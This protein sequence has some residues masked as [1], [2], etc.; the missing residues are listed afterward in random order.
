[1]PPHPHPSFGHDAPRFPPPIPA[2]VQVE[3]RLGVS[4]QG[5]GG[6]RRTSGGGHAGPNHGRDHGREQGHEY[7]HDRGLGGYGAGG[8]NAHPGHP[9][10]AYGPRHDDGPPGPPHAFRDG[11]GRERYRDRPPEFRG[12]ADSPRR[13]DQF[14][15][16]G[17]RR[18]R[19]PDARRGGPPARRG[20]PVRSGDAEIEIRQDRRKQ[21]RVN[22]TL[23]LRNVSFEADTAKLRAAFQGFGEI[24]EWFDMIATRGMVFCHYYD[25]RAAQTAKEQMHGTTIDRRPIDV[26]YSLPKEK[27]LAG[28]CD[29]T[30]N[31]GAVMVERSPPGPLGEGDLRH[32]ASAYGDVKRV[33][34]TRNNSNLVVEFW[35]SRAAAAFARNTN[36]ANHRGARLDARLVWEQAEVAEAAPEL[37]QRY[38]ARP[39]APPPPPPGD[40]R[41]EN[42]RKVQ[43]LLSNLG[44]VVSAPP[45]PAGHS[46]H[47]G[48]PQGPPQH[49]NGFFSPP[50]V[51]PGLSGHAGPPLGQAQPPPRPPFTSLVPNAPPPAPHQ[52]Y[53]QQQSQAYPGSFQ[54]PP[55]AQAHS[56]YQQPVPPHPTPPPPQ[57]YAPPAP[58]PGYGQAPPP[59]PA[60]QPFTPPLSN[61]LPADVLALLARQT[62][63][64]P[65]SSAHA[66]PPSQSFPP[67][68][69][70]YQPPA[71][72]SAPPYGQPAPYGQPPPGPPPNAQAY[73]A[74]AYAGQQAPPPPPPG[75]GYDP[76]AS[77]NV[78]SLLAMLNQ[79]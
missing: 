7:G 53:S 26:H 79:Q 23:F 51:P 17:G 63:A 74:P 67:P 1:M 47:N 3:Q 71:Q 2:P 50:P 62:G 5:W 33:V 76:R 66:A 38:A 12:R 46:S 18:E 6:A 52:P 10:A 29:E 56:S 65:A 30:K 43:S 11:P 48:P 45:P 60:P 40:D 72:Y 57:P 61:A 54:A 49:A 15:G 77:S 21:E 68:A 24:K 73:G 16:R 44:S 32:M 19:S 55:P 37:P 31:N 20:Q 36:G 41:F 58:P 70:A 78:G 14:E 42:A 28:D 8:P 22:R 34:R 25:L 4:D 39:P 59:A 75:R 9:P 64:T 27:D 13:E 69:P 35:D